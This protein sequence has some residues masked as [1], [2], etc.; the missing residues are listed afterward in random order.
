MRVFIVF[1]TLECS[2]H[3]F[4]DTEKGREN[5]TILKWS[6]RLECIVGSPMMDI[7]KFGGSLTI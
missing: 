1:Y 2:W 5:E 6:K 4:I 3:N 7:S